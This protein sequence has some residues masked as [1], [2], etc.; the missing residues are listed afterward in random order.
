MKQ[1]TLVSRYDYTRSSC[2]NGWLWRNRGHRSD[3]VIRRGAAPLLKGAALGAALLLG[4]RRA[5]R[6]AEEPV[7]LV[8]RPAR[9]RAPPLRQD[10]NAGDSRSECHGRCLDRRR[11]AVRERRGLFVRRRHRH[12]LGERAVGHEPARGPGRRAAP[13]VLLDDLAA[14]AKAN[15]VPSLLPPKPAPR[16]VASP[17]V[18]SCAPTG[19]TRSALASCEPQAS[20]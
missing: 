5:G 6:H 13:Q 12:R 10:R 19:Q 14:H 16:P 20:S 8:R 18:P 11:P 2:W 3:K 4:R 15:P 17:I 9:R 7:A 1:P